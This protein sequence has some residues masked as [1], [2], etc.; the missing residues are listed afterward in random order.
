MRAR[1]Q[2]INKITY[3]RGVA[4]CRWNLLGN[5]LIRTDWQFAEQSAITVAEFLLF[6][7]AFHGL[8]ERT[9]AVQ[10]ERSTSERPLWLAAAHSR[11]WRGQLLLRLAEMGAWWRRL[12]GDD[13]CLTA[14]T[15]NL[16]VDDGRHQRCYKAQTKVMTTALLHYITFENYL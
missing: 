16:H 14:L 8:G 9:A 10:V 15:L 3:S 4:K 5:W 11:P 13:W 7:G 6:N 1:D 2:Q 12:A